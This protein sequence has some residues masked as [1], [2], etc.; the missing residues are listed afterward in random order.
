MK[1]R[2][3]VCFKKNATLYEPQYFSVTYLMFLIV[4]PVVGWVVLY[5]NKGAY[6]NYKDGILERS[7][8]DLSDAKTFIDK[9]KAIEKST[10]DWR[11]NKK[12][13]KYIKY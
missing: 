1:T 11:K 3:K 8:F 6:L 12:I 13:T 9:E 7:F 5:Q 4:I 10:K 2:I